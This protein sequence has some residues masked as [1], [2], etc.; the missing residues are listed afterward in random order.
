MLQQ[1]EDFPLQLDRLYLRSRSRYPTFVA[2][3]ADAIVGL[4]N[5]AFNMDFAN[6]RDFVEF[7]LPLTPH[8]FVERIY[9]Q[10]SA[11]CA[12]V[13]GALVA[14]LA[15]EASSHG[16]GFIGGSLDLASDATVRR[17]FFER[18]GF[19]ISGF[20]TFGAVTSNVL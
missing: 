6:N 18:R 1:S 16:C 9:F 13:G 4:L 15:L 7:G 12:G 5:G 19:T 2:W 11:R 14:H 20:D 17:R 3:N 10:P 8:A